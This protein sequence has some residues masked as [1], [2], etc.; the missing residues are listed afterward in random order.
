MHPLVL[1]EI[2]RP[3]SHRAPRVFIATSQM[4][5]DLRSPRGNSRPPTTPRATGSHGARNDWVTRLGWSHPWRD[6]A[7]TVYIAARSACAPILVSPPRAA[8]LQS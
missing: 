8:L 5:R 4:H 1:G 7:L 2:D 3:V 6:L